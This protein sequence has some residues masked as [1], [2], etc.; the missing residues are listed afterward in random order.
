MNKILVAFFSATGTTRNVAKKIAKLAEADLFEINPSIPYSRA[1][2]N[3]TDKNSRSSVEMADLN[4]RV[5][6]ANKV[7]NMDQYKTIFVG[8]PIWW[9]KAPHIINSFLEQYDLKG[10]KIIP[11]ATSG[12]SGMG[13]TNTYLAP[14]CKGADLVEGKVINGHM[15]CQALKEWIESIK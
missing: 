13:K 11:F 2:L 6:I 12:G 4:T 15:S 1:D 9:Y 14:S 7:E 8:F 10:K 5:S 3:W